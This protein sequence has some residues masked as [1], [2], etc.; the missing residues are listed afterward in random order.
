M[1]LPVSEKVARLI[2]VSV[3]PRLV[4]P[5][6]VPGPQTSVRVPKLPT[7]AAFDDE[8]DVGVAA[9][10]EAAGPALEWPQAAS[11]VAARAA[12]AM[13]AVTDR[14]RGWLC[15]RIERS[16]MASFRSCWKALSAFPGGA[17]PGFIRHPEVPA[18]VHVTT[19]PCC[20]S[21]HNGV[22]SIF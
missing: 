12:T 19:L 14:G 17:H 2:A 16:D 5:F 10:D 4:A 3:T 15:T 8:A 6:A 1:L 13:L 7:G 20:D 9:E 22:T 11:P 18:S 21:A